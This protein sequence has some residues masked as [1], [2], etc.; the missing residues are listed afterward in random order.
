M[1]S[2]LAHVFSLQDRSTLFHQANWVATSMS[3][4]AGKNLFH[5][6]NSLQN[7]EQNHLWQRIIFGKV[8]SNSLITPLALLK[9]AKNGTSINFAKD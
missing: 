3:V 1:L 2:L 9:S 4:D 6:M 5:F 7:F 8:P